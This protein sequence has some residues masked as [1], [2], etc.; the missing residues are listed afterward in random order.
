MLIPD[1]DKRNSVCSHSPLFKQAVFDNEPC[2]FKDECAH[3]VHSDVIVVIII[4]EH[5]PYIQPC[6]ALVNDSL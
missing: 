4:A 3:M 5:T 1:I 6:T 2:H